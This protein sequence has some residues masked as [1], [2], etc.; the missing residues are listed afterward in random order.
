MRSCNPL[1]FDTAEKKCDHLFGIG[2][3]GHGAGPHWLDR[4][5][6]RERAYWYKH[7][8]TAAATISARLQDCTKGE[9]EI[10]GSTHP[11]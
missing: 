5:R 1:S 2:N 8:E 6:R 7:K 9:A 11:K 10:F 3:P 4:A